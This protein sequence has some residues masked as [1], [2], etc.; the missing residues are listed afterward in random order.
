MQFIRNLQSILTC[1]VVLGTICMSACSIRIMYNY[2]DW[3]IPFY[4]DDYVT[5]T[6]HQEKLFDRGIIQFLQMASCRG[7]AK[8]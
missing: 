5:L 4:I 1:T 2:L 8:V 6:D 7:V 3:I